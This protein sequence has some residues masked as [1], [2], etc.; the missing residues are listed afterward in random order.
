[1]VV[2]IFVMGWILVMAAFG[3]GL[4][5]VMMAAFVMSCIVMVCIGDGLYL[6]MVV[7]SGDG[8]CIL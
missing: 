6:V 2:A 3:G 7:A 8:C 4:Y 5:C 1:M